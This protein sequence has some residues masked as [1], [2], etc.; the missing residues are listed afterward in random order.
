[1]KTLKYMADLTGAAFSMS[2]F[3]LIGLTIPLPWQQFVVLGFTLLIVLTACIMISQY[4]EQAMVARAA[5]PIEGVAD[6][7]IG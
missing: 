4:V 2:M 5:K 7:H 1:M 3:V 6:E